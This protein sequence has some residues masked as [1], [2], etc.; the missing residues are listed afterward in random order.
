MKALII[1]GGIGGFNIGGGIGGLA[2]GGIGGIAGG[3]NGNLGIAGATQAQ[4]LIQLITQVVAPGEWGLTPYQQA[5]QQI[6]GG[7]AAQAGFMGIAGNFNALGFAGINAAP[8]SRSPSI[9][10]P[11]VGSRRS[12]ISSARSK[13]AV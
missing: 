9:N 4:P 12:P 3:F 8:A 6:Q 7:F 10:S 5:F 13:N 2:G 11:A 1:G